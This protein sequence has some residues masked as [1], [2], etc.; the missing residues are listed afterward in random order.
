MRCW[1]LA[2]T[3]R[4]PIS[5]VALLQ[6]RVRSSPVAVL[7][8]CVLC[9]RASGRAAE[10]VLRS[11]LE[12]YPSA[13]ELAVADPAELADLCRPLGLQNVR[14]A[15]LKGVAL[16]CLSGAATDPPW[17]AHGV[18]KYGLDAWY[19]FVSGIVPHNVTDV[20]LRRYVRW[21]RGRFAGDPFGYQS[22]VTGSS[23]GGS[24]HRIRSTYG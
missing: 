13:V 4:L 22:W 23:C 15:R 6:E 3:A 5:P 24:I 2:G 11:V 17:G 16:S 7:A 19:L 18:G 21:A 9:S 10:P 12:A 14:A 20:H 1:V 8:A